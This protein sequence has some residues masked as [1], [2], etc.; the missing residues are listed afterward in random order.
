MYLMWFDDNPKH[1]IDAKI[2]DAIA[3]YRE[4]YGVLP[5]VALVSELDQ[6]PATVGGVRTQAEKRVA[7]NNVHVGIEQA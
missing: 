4:R 7:R 6:A 5:N 2:T 1:T 3:A